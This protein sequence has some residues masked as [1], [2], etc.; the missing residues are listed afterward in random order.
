MYRGLRHIA[1]RIRHV[2]QRI[3]GTLY[4]GLRHVLQRITARC[5]EDSAR[6][7]E[8]YGMLYRGFSTLYRGLRHVVQRITAR[9]TGDSARCTEDFYFAPHWANTHSFILHPCLIQ[10][11]STFSFFALGKEICTASLLHIQLLHLFII[12]LR[13]P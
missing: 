4:R 3:K 13:A 11:I 8:D 7:T 10:Y 5:T 12:I 9:C 1:Q 6:C 2:V